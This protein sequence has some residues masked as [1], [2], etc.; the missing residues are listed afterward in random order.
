[1]ISRPIEL[2]WLDASASGLRV[3]ALEPYFGGSHSEFLRGLQA[4]SSHHVDLHT[5]PGRHWKWRM[6]GGALTL[7]RRSTEELSTPDPRSTP[8]VLFASSMLDVPAYLA[9]AHP[10]AADAPLLLYFHENQLTYPLPPGVERD[11]GYGL[12][13]LTGA[14]AADA[15][16]FN[17]EFHRREFLQAAQAL[18]DDVPDEAPLWA[19]DAVA[20]KARVLPL[21]CD[22]R[23]FDAFGPDR[24]RWGSPEQGPL[25]VWNQ[26]WEYDKAPGELFR[27]MYALQEQGVSF[28]L[29][30][31]GAN[32]GLPSAEF[33]AAKSRLAGHIVQWG[34]VPSFAEY[35]SLLWTADV[36]ISTAL[37]E[38]FGVAVVEAVYCGCR[39]VL[40]RR[41]SYP[42]MVPGEAHEQVLYD[43]DPVPLLRRALAGEGEWS[44]DWQ[45][46][47]VAPYDWGNMAR[48]YDRAIWECW[49]Q[50]GA[51]RRRAWE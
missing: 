45:R 48:R 16:Y 13:Q 20:D 34:R 1:V 6:H 18:L 41:L 11:L 31:A 24:T 38:F 2:P 28:R 5:L 7:A 47:W 17:S 4:Y 22:L 50:G 51:R 42:E 35:A 12:R 40:P 27:A 23:R 25:V 46:T 15:V 30:V 9:L 29:A 32:Q 33:V 10:A 43:D 26:R 44:K 49:E 39:P 36:V 8:Q 3:W 21:G 19:G 37:H 14:L